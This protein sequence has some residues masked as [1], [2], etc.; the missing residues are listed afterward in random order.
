MVVVDDHHHFHLSVKAVSRRTRS[1][2]AAAAYRAGADYIDK[3]TGRLHDYTR[4]EGVL[5]AQVIVPAG[6]PEWAMD[7]ERLFNAAER[8]EGM[9]LYSEPRQRY[10]TVAREIEIALPRE[11][12]DE[13]NVQLA[14]DVAREVVDRHGVAAQVC[15]HEPHKEGDERNIHAHILLTTR[16]VEQ[17]GLGAKTREWDARP[18]KKIAYEN[19]G[20]AQVELWRE[21]YAELQN[22]RLAEF[23]HDVTVDHRS[24]AAQGIEDRAAQQHMGPGATALMRK[25]EREARERG[26]EWNEAQSWV[27]RTRHQ[28]EHVEAW[29]RERERRVGIDRQTDEQIQE[30]IERLKEPP[31]WLEDR[32]LEVA[33]VRQQSEVV[34]GHVARYAAKLTKA[35]EDIAKW[36]KEH[37]VEAFGAQI[38]AR[39]GMKPPVELALLQSRRQGVEEALATVRDDADLHRNMLNAHD[40]ETDGMLRDYRWP[41]E[42]EAARLE[43]VLELRAVD[44]EMQSIGREIHDIEREGARELAVERAQALP[45]R[46]ALEVI[47]NDLDYQAACEAFDNAPP[48][49]ELGRALAQINRLEIWPVQKAAAQIAAGGEMEFRA[50]ARAAAGIRETQRRRFYEE[51]VRQRAHQVAPAGSEPENAEPEKAGPEKAGPEKP[52]PTQP[53]RAEAPVA[54]PAKARRRPRDR[55]VTPET[56]HRD[57][58]TAAK[59]AIRREFTRDEMQSPCDALLVIDQRSAR[60]RAQEIF[61]HAPGGDELREVLAQLDK[62]QGSL[63][64]YAASTIEESNAALAPKDRARR[65]LE[66]DHGHGR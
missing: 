37:R 58:L 32:E 42:R 25:E 18:S 29:E 8:A 52:T 24:L 12:T 22:E 6:A 44:R 64:R 45:T 1:S 34:D 40:R 43:S 48:G 63:V 17:D 4:R 31:E 11:L 26:Q 46:E 21:R 50:D 15:V 35:D 36:K 41:R 5:D 7:A 53:A 47:Q 51:P 10:P 20:P 56:Q 27:R 49:D 13:Q 23:G 2:V 65:D 60:E 54:R 9:R 38:R 14:Q 66:D 19:T 39:L 3:R 16:V 33:V 61:D 62:G 28:P 59:A 57:N 55:T 30:R